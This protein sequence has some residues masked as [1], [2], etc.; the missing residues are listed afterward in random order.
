MEDSER[1]QYAGE[2]ETMAITEGK[3]RTKSLWKKLVS[4][5]VSTSVASFL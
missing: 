1:V 3:E 2:M 5:A 4:D